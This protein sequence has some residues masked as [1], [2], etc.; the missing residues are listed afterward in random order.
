MEKVK[1]TYASGWRMSFNAH[2]TAPRL[3]LEWIRDNQKRFKYRIS[4]TIKTEADESEILNDCFV[5]RFDNMIRE[6]V[7]DCRDYIQNNL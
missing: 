2:G 7:H 1:L 3:F 4:F 5:V 6:T